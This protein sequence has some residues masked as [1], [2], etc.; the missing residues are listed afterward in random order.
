MKGGKDKL[1]WVSFSFVLC[2]DSADVYV[3]NVF[4]QIHSLLSAYIGY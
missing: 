3:I 2:I 4:H 1:F